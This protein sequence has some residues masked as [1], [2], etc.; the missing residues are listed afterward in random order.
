MPSTNT[1][2]HS[3]FDHLRNLDG[4]M[5]ACGYDDNHPWREEIISG[6]ESID[7]VD[8]IADDIVGAAEMVGQLLDLA[9]LAC[10]D[11]ADSFKIE[12]AIRAARRY[13]TDISNHGEL[14]HVANHGERLGG[15]LS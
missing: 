6:I 5:A 8:N 15:A 10:L 13:A 2:P 4:Y 3:S 1:F 9:L 14:I 7:V 11:V 12:A